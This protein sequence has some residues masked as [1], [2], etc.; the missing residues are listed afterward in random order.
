MINK[1]QILKNKT[2]WLDAPEE[3]EIEC[4]VLSGEEI[5]KPRITI[6]FQIGLTINPTSIVNVNMVDVIK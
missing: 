4:L 2:E 3:S 1:G 5:G 6:E